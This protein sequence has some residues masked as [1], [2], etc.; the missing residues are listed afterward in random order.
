MKEPALD[1]DAGHA[2][3]NE[4]VLTFY[5]DQH[6]ERI[7]DSSMRRPMA[8]TGKKLPGSYCFS[9]ALQP[10]SPSAAA[11]SWRSRKPPGRKWDCWRRS[12]SGAARSC[13]AILS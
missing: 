7:G 11:T 10:G 2:A 13:R 4:L 8:P 3:P 6:L 1:P 9:P 5:D 12:A